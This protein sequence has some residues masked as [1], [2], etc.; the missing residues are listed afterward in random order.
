[1]I[2]IPLYV[3]LILYFG[4]LLV[5]AG[6]WFVNMKHL[7][8]TGTLTIPSFAA[9]LTFL[10]AVT[11]LLWA[12]WGALQGVDWREPLVVFNISAIAKIFS[13]P[14]TAFVQ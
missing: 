4:L 12:T 13:G 9:T 5:L 2:T 1:M 14:D 6:L 7:F 10:I 3:P 8:D 11:L